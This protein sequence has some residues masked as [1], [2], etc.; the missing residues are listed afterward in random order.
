MHFVQSGTRVSVI[1]NL[2][3]KK[4]VDA[5]LSDQRRVQLT[6]RQMLIKKNRFIVEQLFDVIRL[7]AKLNLPFRGHDEKTISKNRGI[8]REFIEFLG[9]YR[10][11]LENAP[12]NCTYLSHRIQN[13]MIT[14]L[15]EQIMSN[16]VYSFG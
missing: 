1:S 2:L 12:H 15:G 6:A 3:L 11:H 16:I 5:M 4:P 14:L 13:E 9:R 7:L 10:D 8:F